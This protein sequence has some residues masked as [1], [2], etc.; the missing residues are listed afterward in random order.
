MLQRID[1]V[2]S[3][4]SAFN[5]M[6]Q[7]ENYLSDISIGYKLKGLIKIRASMLNECAFCIDM[8]TSQARAKGESEQRIYALSAWR[9]SKLFN[10][11]E[12]IALAL[13]E[14]ITLTN[15]QDLSD[16]T[17]QQGLE[18]FGEKGFVEIIMQITAI[19]AWNRIA[20]AT[21]MEKSADGE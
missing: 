2:K 6:L 21:R 14:E 20:I 17:Y 12:R 11:E 19:N 9:K 16:Q 1:F 4:T 5:T 8:H 15:P 10:E 18:Q 7:M 3:H 13:T